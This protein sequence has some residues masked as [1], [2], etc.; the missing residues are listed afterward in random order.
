MDNPTS[1]R[2]SGRGKGG[3]TSRWILRASTKMPGIEFPARPIKENKPQMNLGSLKPT[4]PT[5]L[6]QRR[7]RKLTGKPGGHTSPDCEFKSRRVHQ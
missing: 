6:K 5:L 1:R 4:R 7:A 3:N 2:I